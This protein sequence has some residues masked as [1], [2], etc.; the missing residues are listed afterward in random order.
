MEEVHAV[1]SESEQL[2]GADMGE[3]QGRA[4]HIEADGGSGFVLRA[5]AQGWHG[6]V[7]G[8]GDGGDSRKEIGGVRE[9]MGKIGERSKIKPHRAPPQLQSRAHELWGSVSKHAP[10][11]ESCAFLIPL[12]SQREE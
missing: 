7:V 10:K 6:Q 2:F 4:V 9:A 1:G 11:K 5:R 3:G 8:Q 12:I